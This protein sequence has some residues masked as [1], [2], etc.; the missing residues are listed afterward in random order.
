[1]DGIVAYP[2]S[3]PIRPPIRRFAKDSMTNSTSAPH[4]SQPELLVSVR[5]AQ[6]AA[7]VRELGVDWIDLKDPDSGA[8]GAADQRTCS[9]VALVLKEH[10]QTSA[11]LGEL[12]DLDLDHCRAIARFFSIL[13]VGLSHISDDW[14]SKLLQLT[15]TLQQQ[16][17]QARIVPVIYADWADCAAAAPA[18]VIEFA[19]ANVAFTPFLLIDTFAKDGQH[20]LSHWSLNDLEA[21]VSKLQEQGIRVVLAGSLNQP[22][23]VDV[24]G[25]RPAAIGVRGAVCGQ[26]RTS[27]IMPSK[28]KE[29]LDLL[30]KTTHTPQQNFAG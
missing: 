21:S 23:V 12:H 16:N 8:L 14:Q 9:E 10:R 28:V 6:E 2:D 13:K 3:A 11:A 26:G 7:L 20:L 30:H 15:K 22:Q 1:M 25:L 18:E 17:E 29:L 5:D 24:L 4:P 27:P 19:L